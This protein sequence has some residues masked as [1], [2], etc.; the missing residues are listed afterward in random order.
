[1]IEVWS[2]TVVDTE[3]GSTHGETTSAGTRTP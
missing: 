1:M 3:P 2:K